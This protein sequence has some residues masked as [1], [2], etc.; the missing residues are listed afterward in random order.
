MPRY[1]WEFLIVEGWRDDGALNH[2]EYVTRACFC[3]FACTVVENG[4]IQS[5]TMALL[6]M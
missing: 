4:L 1:S 5:T 3:Q 2:D 6:E